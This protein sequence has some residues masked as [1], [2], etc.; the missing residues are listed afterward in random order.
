M[1][2]DVPEE[3]YLTAWPEIGWYGAADMSFQT[4]GDWGKPPPIG[5]KNRP[6]GTSFP[7]PFTRKD[8]FS[9]LL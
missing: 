7:S 5:T 9:A 6:M 8:S 4:G 3:L 1:T 2:R